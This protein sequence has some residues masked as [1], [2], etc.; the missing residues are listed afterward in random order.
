V[1][2]TDIDER[3]ILEALHHVPRER[4]GD[5]LHFL[6]PLKTTGSP[7]TGLPP[8][9]SGKDL[10]GSDLIGIW[11]DRTDIVDSREFARRLRDQASKRTNPGRSDAP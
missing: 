11:A 2:T 1:S 4:W 7:E 9:R 3:A 10:V 8:V 6:D 5:A